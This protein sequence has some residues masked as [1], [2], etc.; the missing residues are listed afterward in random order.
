MA[1]REQPVLRACRLSAAPVSGVLELMA[2]ERRAWH[3]YYDAID[4]IEA[5][6]GSL[7]ARANA[8]LDDCRVSTAD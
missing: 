1:T 7:A 2:E 6:G 3:A 4:A 5:G 8:I